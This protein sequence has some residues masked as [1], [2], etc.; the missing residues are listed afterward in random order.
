[1]SWLKTWKRSIGIWAVA[2]AWA[3][4]FISW[5]GFADPDAFYHAKMAAL[6]WAH[7]PL[8]SFPWL[9]LT[10]F[11][12]TFADLHFGFHLF[13]APFTAVFGL[14]NGSRIA[15]VVLVGLCLTVFDLVVRRLRFRYALL[16]VA[17]LLF[18]E[19]FLF[20]LTIGKATPLALI[21]FLLGILAVWK[22]RWVLSGLVGSAFAFSYA[23]WPFLAGAAIL[24]TFGDVLY[25]M[26]VENVPL[27]RAVV[28]T[29]WREIGSVLVGGVVGLLAHPNALNI[30]KLSWTQIVTIGLGTPYGH[31]VLGSEWLPIGPGQLVVMTAPWLLLLIL[32]CAGIALAPRRPFASEIARFVA[33]FGWVVAVFLALTL[34]SQRSIE[35]LIPVAAIWTAAIWS[36]VDVQRF[37]DSYQKMLSSMQPV[38]RWFMVSAVVSAVLLLL[39]R[40]VEILWRSFHP[41]RYPDTVYQVSM[42][43][44]SERARPGDRVFHTDWDE[45]PPL[46]AADDRLRYVSGLDPT[47]LF[48][49]SSTLSDQVRDVTWDLS[50]S[51]QDQ[52]WALIHDGLHARFVFVSKAHHQVFLDRILQDPRYVRIADATDSAAFLVTASSTNHVPPN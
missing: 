26:I 10:S 48:V 8:K 39:G 49:A 6:I 13:V 16:W 20:R 1:M 28:Q 40:Q 41:I 15:S 30:F 51:T 24:L 33:S 4:L 46:F 37:R 14:F 32:G 2:S 5:T 22:R 42:D 43:A 19:P 25:E 27:R 44:I 18:S 47:F 9:D 45:F 12:Q 36:L 3:S 17:V 31:V 35:Y 34:K 38:L 7:G 50:T 11:G 52:T 29:R 23:G 21:W